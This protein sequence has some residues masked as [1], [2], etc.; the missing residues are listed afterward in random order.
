[1]TDGWASAPIDGDD[2]GL[3]NDALRRLYADWRAR[4]RGR[5][6]PARRDFDILDLKYIVGDLQLLQVERDPLR[7]RF[8]VH[9]TNAT[10]RIGFDLT[11]RTVDDYPDPEYRAMVHNLYAGVVEARRPRRV[12]QASY[13]L[14]SVILRWEGVILPLSDD[15]ETVN[16]LMVGLHLLDAPTR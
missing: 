8:R 10:A 12:M 5:L 7:F 4:L 2:L 14:P 16:M 9:A 3:A 6:M 15:G 13:E 11:G 1:M